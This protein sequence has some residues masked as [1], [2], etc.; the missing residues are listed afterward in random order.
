MKTACGAVLIASQFTDVVECSTGRSGSGRKAPDHADIASDKTPS[1]VP[2]TDA[3]GASDVLTD[4]DAIE[5]EHYYSLIGGEG[6]PV[7]DYRYDLFVGE[8]LHTKAGIYAEGR[9][10]AA[11]GGSNTRLVTWLSQDSASKT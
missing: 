3:V 6:E 10:I 5:V 1:A 7:R 8:E 2:K 9:T 11:V 4:T